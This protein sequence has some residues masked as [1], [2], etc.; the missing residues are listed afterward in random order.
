LAAGLGAVTQMGTGEYVTMA[1]IVTAMVGLLQ[2]AMGAMQ[3]GFVANLLSRP[4]IT[5][6]TAAAALI[7]S[8]SQLGSLLGV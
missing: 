2:I 1:I 5:G 6:L 3:L 7:I 8:V 4:V